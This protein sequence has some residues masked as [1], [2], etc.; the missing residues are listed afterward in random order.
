MRLVLKKV[1]GH[2]DAGLAESLWQAQKFRSRKETCNLAGYDD[3]RSTE[4]LLTFGVDYFKND[5]NII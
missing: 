3:F 2:T 5:L 1:R 4:A